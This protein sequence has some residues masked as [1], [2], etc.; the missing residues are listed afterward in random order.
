M[1]LLA[2]RGRADLL[3]HGGADRRV[4]RGAVLLGHGAALLSVYDG[5]D[6][7]V[8]HV[9]DVLT[10]GLVEAPAV[11]SVLRRHLDQLAAVLVSLR[12]ER[13]D[14]QPEDK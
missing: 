7:R 1:A 6:L 9:A 4:R 12:S 2:R 10:L 3:V 14:R 5:A 11:L 8:H 13:R